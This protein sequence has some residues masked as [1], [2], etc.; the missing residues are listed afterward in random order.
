MRDRA[1][2]IA[3]AGDA[4]RDGSADRCDSLLQAFAADLHRH[5]LSDEERLSCERQLAWLRALAVA[6]RTGLDQAQAVLRDIAAAAGGLDVYDRSGR[7][8][9]TTDLSRVVQRF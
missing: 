7:Q 2:L 6:S 9:V 8:R 1:S 3:R 5:P 4:L